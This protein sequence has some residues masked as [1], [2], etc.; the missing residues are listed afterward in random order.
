MLN[1][2]RIGMSHNVQ[3]CLNSGITAHIFRR[4][5]LEASIAFGCHRNG[6]V[7]TQ[8]KSAR[9]ASQSL[10]EVVAKVTLFRKVA[11]ILGQS[12]PQFQNQKGVGG[13]GYPKPPSDKH[14]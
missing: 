2:D 11:G 6:C 13:R 9:A 5:L 3:N 14:F 8:K 4:T 1:V 7:T 10:C 12:P